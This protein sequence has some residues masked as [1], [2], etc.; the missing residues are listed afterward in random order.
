MDYQKTLSLILDQYQELK[1]LYFIVGIYYFL[2]LRQIYYTW[3]QNFVFNQTLILESNQTLP[4][5]SH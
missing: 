1:I 2:D 3:Q 5:L 4:L